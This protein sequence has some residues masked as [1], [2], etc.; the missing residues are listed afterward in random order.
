[1]GEKLRFTRT[2]RGQEKLIYDGY[3]YTK[4][5]NQRNGIVWRC[6]FRSECSVCITVSND[7][8]TVIKEPP[9]HSNHA[10]DWGRLQAREHIEELKEAASTSREPI[11]SIMQKNVE[12]VSSEASMKMPKKET[13][14]RTLRNVRKK[15]MPPEPR[16]INDLQNIPDRY[17]KT[18]DG[19]RWLLH[20]DPN[21]ENKLIIFATDRHLRYLLDASYWI[22]DG[23]FKSSPNIFLQIYAIHV[24]INDQWFP[25][26]LTLMERKT[27]QSY[28]ILFTILKEEIQIKFDRTLNPT[29]I[30]TDYESAVIDVIKA[31]F[32]HAEICG[33]L[34]H[35]SQSFWRRVQLEGI[36][37]EY[38]REGNEELRAQFH[39]LIGLA[40]VPEHDVVEAFDLL[41]DNA[42]DLLSAIFDYVEDNYIRGRRRGRGHQRPLFPPKTWNCYQRTLQNLPRTT[43][44][45]EA[46]HRRINTLM[47]KPHPSFYHVVE[48]LQNEVAE[49]HRDITRLQSGFSPKKKKRKYINV[50]TRISRLVERYENF[51]DDGDI[52]GY[53]RAIG[54]NIA[55]SF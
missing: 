40:F 31:E 23:T 21:S 18:L 30:S 35:L 33:C 44:S 10:P 49:I 2:S 45:C 11:A 41:S 54:H 50:D 29:Y 14:K 37:E 34:F 7:R 25:V 17:T 6:D 1:M 36:S 27:K 48:Q 22:M 12:R 46:W 43:N 4:H 24:K 19:D 38:Q 55:G 53:L 9:E 28:Q 52:L 16:S 3:M 8:Q 5:R 47:G 42:D 13:I 32:P 20:Y 39:S 51:K 26:I 15:N